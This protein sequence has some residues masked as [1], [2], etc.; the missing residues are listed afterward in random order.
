MGI[1]VVARSTSARQQLKEIDARLAEARPEAAKLRKAAEKAVAEYQKTKKG[2]RTAEK[3][4]AGMK[5]RE[6]EV[7]ALTE[8]KV[9]VLE[10]L[11]SGGGFAR[12]GRD[13]AATNGG[14]GWAAMARDL[15]AGENRV[16][17]RL[18][19]LTPRQAFAAIGPGEGLHA[20]AIEA[21][22]APLA[23]DRRFIFPYLPSTPIDD[24]E[25]AINEYRQKGSRTVTGEVI[26]DPMSVAEKATL[27][28]E[29]ELVT[30]SLKQVAIVTPEIPDRFLQAVDTAA[31]WLRNEMDYQLNL[32]ID[33]HLLAQIAAA[34]PTK[35]KS[36][37]TNI[38]RARNAVAAMRNAGT[39][40]DLL[41]LNPTEASALDV[42]KSGTAGLEQYVFATRESGSSSPLWGC[43]IIESV[44]VEKP[45]VIDSQLIGQIYTGGAVLLYDPYSG[46]SRNTSRL[47][48]EA[49]VL[50]HIRSSAAV[51]EIA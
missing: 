7:K 14:A 35:G 31:A 39:N 3:A 26:R 18:A 8:A 44:H 41:V 51:Y 23:A 6:A 48:L 27:A 5:E 40:P 36:G 25:L 50:A 29:T 19:D 22:F 15:A 42:I 11:G 33:A 43:T 47:R 24:S 2:V 45:L 21:P 30:P 4:V 49:D 17:G 38:E 28:L 46:M 13:G 16:E 10:G 34:S 20:P 32:A 1:A 37:T 12:P 9:E